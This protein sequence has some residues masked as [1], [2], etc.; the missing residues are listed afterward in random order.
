MKK[1]LLLAILG[2]ALGAGV[3]KTQNPDGTV[4]TFQTQAIALK[5]RLKA[6]VDTVVQ[7]G[8]EQSAGNGAASGTT[9]AELTQRLAVLEQRLNEGAIAQ[10]GSDANDAA[11]QQ[12][13]QSA[14]L[15]I[16]SGGDLTEATGRNTRNLSELGSR[17]DATEATLAELGTQLQ[18]TTAELMEKNSLLEKNTREQT[19]VNASIE[20]LQGS[21]EQIRNSLSE[22]AAGNDAGI[23]RLDAIDSRLELV[24]RRLDEQTYESDIATLND[25][26]K[27]MQESLVEIRDEIK[28]RDSITRESLADSA[29]SLEAL[30][31]RI[32][33]LA[34]AAAMT[35]GDA[36][37]STASAETN[38]QDGNAEARAGGS[39]AAVAALSATLDDRFKALEARLQ[40]VNADS[41]KVA[42]LNEQLEALRTDMGDLKQQS[43]DTSQSIEQINSAIDD[44]KTAG[45]SL[46][47]D[48]IQAEIRNQLALAQSRFES[49]TGSGNA[50]ALE[51]LLTNTRER[52]QTLE[53]RV[54]EL[55]AASSE[56]NSAQKNQSNLESQIEA[57]ERRLEAIN[58]NT[59]PDVSRRL[60]SVQEQVQQ[61]N[62]QQFVTLDDMRAQ[63]ES[64]AVQYKIYFDRNSAEITPDAATVLNSFIAQEKNRTVGVSIFGFTDRLGS[65]SYNQQLALQRAT[66]VRSYL[67]QNGLDYTKIKALTGLGEEAAAAALPDN[68]DD[69]Q[70]RAV[71]LYAA[72]P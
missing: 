53:Q 16:N 71:V 30:S 39:S 29:E 36:E 63:N 38:S 45:E 20:A 51:D 18:A 72:Q 31:L 66:N 8:G 17:L 24:V 11:I 64:R 61:L 49:D 6:G 55:P 52:I 7:A 2:L 69:A 40:T 44:L 43:S 3:W 65:A 48:T 70:L 27:A 21:V 56:A 25:D 28:S 54:Q 68:A 5:D 15:T 12:T 59:A 67:I 22:V 35:A 10:P 58:N 19:D 13:A 50:G 62:E 42:A 1:L 46:S 41:R 23:V 14:D 33:T 32:N 26:L 34:A 60:S 57:L 37:S 47:I 9:A 4:E